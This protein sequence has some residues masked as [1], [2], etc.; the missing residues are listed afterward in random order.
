LNKFIASTFVA[1]VFLQG[2][3]GTE[4]SADE[5]FDEAVADEVTIY[6]ARNIITMDPSRPHAEA[7][8]VSDSEI[9]AVGTLEEVVAAV[10]DRSYEVDPRFENHVIIPGLIDQHVHPLLAALTMN[11][12]IIAIEDWA[13]PHGT[14]KAATDRDEY[15]RRLGEAVAA[16]ADADEALFTWGFHHYFHGKLTRQDLDVISDSRSIVV[17]HRSVHEFILNTPAMEEFGIT[18]EFYATFSESAKSQSN[19]DEGHFWEQGWYPVLYQ[20][21]P[22]LTEPAR[23]KSSLEFVRDYFHASGVTL[24]AEPG[25]M[26]SEKLQEA[27]NAVLSDSAMPFRSYFIVDGKTIALSRT[28]DLIL[29]TEEPLTWGRGNTEF[30]PKQAKLFADGAIFSQ[31][32]QMIDGYTDGHDGEWMMDLE[33]FQEAFDTYW[34]AGYQLHIHQNGDAGLEMVLDVLEAAQK[35]NPRNDHR[36]TIVHFG[37]ST[38]QQVDKIAKLG[39]IVSANP[40]Y[41]TSLADNYAV[42]GIGLQ[43]ADEMVRLGDVVRA[44]I[45]LSLHSDMPMAPGQPLYLVWAAVNRTTV[46]GR[47]A[48]PDQRIRV[49]DALKA[50][51]L[52]AAHSLRLENEVGSLETGKRANLTILG[53]SPYEVDP[54]AIKDIQIWGTMHEGSIHPIEH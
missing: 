5:R 12:E 41:L 20:L 9:I 31:A 24:I 4:D 26:V 32:M 8:S 42:N 11:M 6:T 46:S 40:Y 54:A 15:L 44:G 30:L 29:A 21:I 16:D 35:R 36:T 38:T 39:A 43:R 23:L 10:G 51:T 33:V 14:S 49:E 2:C 53:D 1:A 3:N 19:F 22:A 34:D 17:W 13:L 52:D 47:V 18:P 27:Q 48:G 25:G 45:P 50:V 28:D 37:F 7:I